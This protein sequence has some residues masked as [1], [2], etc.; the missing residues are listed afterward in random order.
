M[1]VLHKFSMDMV[2]IRVITIMYEILLFLMAYINALTR[3]YIFTLLDMQ[4]MQ[5]AKI[6]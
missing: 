1:V 2:S 4:L 6:M 3:Y 5:L